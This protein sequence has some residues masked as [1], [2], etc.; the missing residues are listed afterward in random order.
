MNSPFDWS[1]LAVDDDIIQSFNI[2]FSIQK[3][4]DFESLTNTENWPFFIFN[5]F[6]EFRVM[7]NSFCCYVIWMLLTSLGIDQIQSSS[8]EKNTIDLRQKLHEL[9]LRDIVRNGNGLRSTPFDEQ[10]VDFK[11]IIF[12]IESVFFRIWSGLS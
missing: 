4:Y 11:N 3:R 10:I 1:A 8:S 2:V 5:V 9:L 7:K 6:N 12:I